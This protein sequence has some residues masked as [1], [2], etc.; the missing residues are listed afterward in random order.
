VAAV[1]VP[2][3]L[4]PAAGSGSSF[5]ALAPGVLWAALWPIV[6]GGVL[7]LAL[8]RWADRLPRV[9]EGD[10]VVL[11][12]TVMRTIIPWSEA[13]ERA[14]GCLRRWPVASLSLLSVVV[15][16]SGAMLIWG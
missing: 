13:I 6:V 11:G 1:E 7:A 16:L 10:V 15:I 12:E 9:P 2:W 5:Q 3:A 14:D 4:F 8:W